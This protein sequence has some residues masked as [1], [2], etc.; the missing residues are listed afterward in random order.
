MALPSQHYGHGL[1]PPRDP[2]FLFPL[3]WL[4]ASSS[5]SRDTWYENTF[6]T[7]H[8]S[9]EPWAFAR[10]SGLAFLPFIRLPE[11]WAA[12]LLFTERY[13]SSQQSWGALEVALAVSRMSMRNLAQPRVRFLWSGKLPGSQEEEE[14][15]PVGL[16]PAASP[17]LLCLRMCSWMSWMS[18]QLHC[19]GTCFQAMCRDLEEVDSSSSGSS[20]KERRV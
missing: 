10:S 1:G 18:V 9:A 3:S 14:K 15:K 16:S 7:L 20:P 11:G 13:Q 5:V 2:Y 8:G 19:V 17:L 12:W 6:S 4:H